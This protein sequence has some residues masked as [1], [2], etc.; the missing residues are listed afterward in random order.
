MSKKNSCIR[1]LISLTLLGTL[2]LGACKSTKK[3]AATVAKAPASE[4]KNLPNEVNEEA[5]LLLKTD[6]GDVKIKLSNLTPLHRDNFLKLAAEGFYDSLLFHRVIN[7]FMIQGGDPESKKATK[8]QMLGN[9]DVKY[10]IPAEFNPQLFHKKGALCA[11]RQGDDVNPQKASSGCQFYLV[12][13]KVLSDNDINQFEYRINK[14]VINQISYDLFRIPENE[15]LRVQ[16]GKC[17]DEGK[18]D[19]AAMIA[20]KLDE[21]FISTYKKTPHYEFSPEQ[22]N[23][24]K[25]IGGTPHL[26]GSYTVFG[27]VIEGLEVIDKIASVQTGAADRPVGDVRIRKIIILNQKSSSAGKKAKH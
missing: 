18:K 11:A 24:Y 17:M 16:M 9:G 22:R 21:L 23:T 14:N 25:T 10:T 15:A 3:T 20:K 1:Y 19:S 27:E 8:E 26:D 5:I 12:Q 4:S 6:S 2:L 13:G 7:G